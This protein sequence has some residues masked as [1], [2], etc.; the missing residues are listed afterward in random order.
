MLTDYA[1]AGV[2]GWLAYLLFRTQ[3]AQSARRWWAL[4]FVA[5]ALAALLGGTFHGFRQLLAG[6]VLPILWKM[7]VLTVGIASFGMV[8]GSASA[9]TAGGLRRGLV[10]LALV[11]LVF[12]S[13][14]MLFHDSFIYVIA[15]TGTA[16]AVVAILHVWSAVRRRDSASRWML[17]GVGVSIVAAAVQASHVG[18]HPNF[19]HNDL[20]HLIQIV[21][22]TLFFAGIQRLVDRGR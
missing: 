7:T 14:W 3:A 9:V 1:L 22:M 11:K 12:Y 17:A 5:L 18:L 21:A 19:N 20:Y 13:G 2:S 10:G 6:G 16:L 15:D 8:A 4:A